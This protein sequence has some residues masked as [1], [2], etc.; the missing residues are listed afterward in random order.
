MGMIFYL[1]PIS[2]CWWDEMLE[3]AAHL[4]AC[5]DSTPSKHPHQFSLCSVMPDRPASSWQVLTLHCVSPQVNPA[6]ANLLSNSYLARWRGDAEHHGNAFLKYGG[7]EAGLST[8]KSQQPCCA[9]FVFLP[10]AT[11]W[12][13]LL[14]SSLIQLLF[15]GCQCE[16]LQLLVTIIRVD[17]SV[18]PSPIASTG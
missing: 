12:S 2:C 3:D 16:C 11:H 18:L 7:G 8:R 5:N 6:I 9:Q 13:C 4:T 1:W 14:V 10:H 15:Q 17:P